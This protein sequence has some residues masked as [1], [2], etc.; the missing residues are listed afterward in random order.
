[1][2]H[3]P[4][5]PE[6]NGSMCGLKDLHQDLR[7]LEATIDTY[8]TYNQAPAYNSLK[9]L[10]YSLKKVSHLTTKTRQVY[11]TLENKGMY[12]VLRRMESIKSF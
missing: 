12:Y 2:L 4:E 9:D 10:K 8:C 1:M 11:L 6:V 3:E 7:N 5:W